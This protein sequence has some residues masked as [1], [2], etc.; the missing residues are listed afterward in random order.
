MLRRPRVVLDTNVLISRL[1][2]PNSL[3]AQAV[4]LA[5]DEGDILI[6]RAVLSE[7]V[8]VIGRPKFD[9]YVSLADRK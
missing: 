3:P 2:M 8:E 4:S 7:L 5:V 9:K 1:L 6:S